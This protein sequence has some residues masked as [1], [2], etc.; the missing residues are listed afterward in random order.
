[1]T[2]QPDNQVEYWN[3]VAS[4]KTFTQPLNLA[5]FS[6]FVEKS[7][8]IL[9]FGCGYGRICQALWQSGFH[10]VLGVDFSPKMI[11]RARGLFPHLTF[12]VADSPL[13]F[14]DS[15]FDAVTL[16][17]VLTCIISNEA[18]QRL[19]WE[20][21]RVLR[22][23]GILYIGDF[24]LQEDDRNRVRYEQYYKEFENYGTFRTADGVVLRHHA[25]EWIGTLLRGFRKHE[26]CFMDLLTMNGHQ[27]RGFQYVGE[28]M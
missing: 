3:R 20:L 13:P 24:P 11:E 9:D 6:R 22:P 18:Q 26:L 7:N 8:R 4:S 14:P 21:S 5:L 23:G 28:K 12:E 10:N 16:F 17:A 2:G 27:A 1:M 25:L 15:A 19:V